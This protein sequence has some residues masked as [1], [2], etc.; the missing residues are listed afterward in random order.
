MKKRFFIF[1][2]V[3]ALFAAGA[4]SRKDDA[5]ASKGR[6]SQGPLIEAPA[7]TGGLTEVDQETGVTVVVPDEVKSKWVYVVIEV[8]DKQEDK[9]EEF[10]VVIGDKFAIP[11]S[12]L[13]VNIG[14]F[15]PD[16]QMDGKTITSRSADPNNPSV[17][18]SV[19]QDG[20]QIFPV[21]GKWG[22][23]HGN[24]PQVHSF[25]HE[26]YALTLKGAR[27]LDEEGQ[28]GSPGGH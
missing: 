12:G 1:I 28:P 21:T 20:K 26:R 24:F 17:G 9:Q 10:T 14:P 23:L 11:N 22:W 5:P 25:Q 18:I 3:I 8:N 2:A 27:F 19:E 15:L 7:S 4:C 6:M 13:T 16:F